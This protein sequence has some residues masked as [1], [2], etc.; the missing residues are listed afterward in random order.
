LHGASG[1]E[2]GLLRAE[3]SFTFTVNASVD[4]AF[5][6]FGPAREA[7]WSP[8]WSPRF[9]YPE[10]G[11]VSSEGAVFLAQPKDGRPDSVWVMTVYDERA[12][13]VEYVEFTPGHS[14]T[15]IQV[16]LQPTDS[17][18]S[19]AT[20]SYRRTALTLSARAFIRRFADHFPAERVRWENAINH[21]L[22]TGQPLPIP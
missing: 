5:P 15:E 10:N 21:Y 1:E 3:R 14:V 2:Q 13:R 6:L 8:P 12:H 17:S 7:E 16:V 19:R 4:R 20:I 22:A 11:K 9:I 18:H